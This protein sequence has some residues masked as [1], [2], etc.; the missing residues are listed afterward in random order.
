MNASQQCG[1][2]AS[3]PRQIAL[4]SLRWNP[5]CHVIVGI[6]SLLLITTGVKNPTEAMQG[7][8]DIRNALAPPILGESDPWEKAVY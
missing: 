6:L 8:G 3:H 4:L 5:T 1:T 7:E 2:S